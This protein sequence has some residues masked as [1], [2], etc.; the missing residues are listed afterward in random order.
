MLLGARMLI[1]VQGV[2]SFE[3][4]PAAEF[5]AGDPATVY[6]QLIDQSLDRSID[7]FNPPGRRYMPSPG[8]T[9]NCVVQSIDDNKRVTRFAT[10]PFANDP[11]MWALQFLASDL[12]KGTCNLYLTL[13]EGTVVRSGTVKCAIKIHA[14][15]GLNLAGQGYS[16][17][18]QPA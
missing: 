12:I 15:S 2:N 10:Q 8:A 6:F 1:D 18:D 3:V 7:G 13:T 5:Y 11:S 17:N 9:L 14:N 16:F 4:T